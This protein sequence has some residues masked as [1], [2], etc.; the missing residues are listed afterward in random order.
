MVTVQQI[1]LVVTS[2]VTMVN[3]HWLAII[4]SVD[5]NFA[6][7]FQSQ[8]FPHPFMCFNILSPSVTTDFLLVFVSIF[9]TFIPFLSF[10]ICFSLEELFVIF[11]V[12][13]SDS[14][15]AISKLM[16]NVFMGALTLLSLFVTAFLILWCFVLLMCFLF[17]HGLC[18]F[19]LRK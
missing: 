1:F 17:L 9:L 10:E 16:K 11:I 18:Y 4:L 15:D 5:I 13:L 12:V 7:A 8:K 19:V 2:P 3:D 14:C 6:I